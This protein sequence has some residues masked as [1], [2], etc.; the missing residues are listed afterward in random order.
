MTQ[1]ERIARAHRAA[2]AMDEFFNPALTEIE[3]E[4][5][6]KMITIAASSDPRAP[7][8]IARLANGIS[9]ARQVRARIEKF[10]ADGEIAQA[11]KRIAEAMESMSAPDRRFI[12]MT[13]N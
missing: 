4:Y 12:T 13:P 1:Q 5:A 7:E 11:E 9:V 6:E 8:V 3:T 10:I 2:S